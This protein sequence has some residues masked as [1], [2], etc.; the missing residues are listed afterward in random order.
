[1]ATSVN[2]K[3]RDSLDVSGQL[4][5]KMEILGG[6]NSIQLR[7]TSAM[8]FTYDLATALQEI[9]LDSDNIFMYGYIQDDL[10]TENGEEIANDGS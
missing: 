5:G 7:N 6:Y 9:K 1:M 10:N 2:R 3:Q 8:I 4:R